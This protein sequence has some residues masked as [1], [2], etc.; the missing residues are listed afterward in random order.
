MPDLIV[1]LDSVAQARD[2]R[3]AQEPDPAAAAV[4]AEL[5]GA[6]GVSIALRAER[7]QS[8]E[9]DAKVLRATVRS[10]LLLRIAASPDSVKLASP[11]RPDAAVLVPERVDPLGHEAPFDLNLSS[12]AVQEAAQGLAAA[13]IDALVLVEPD[14]EQVKLA[15][16]AGV[17]GVSLVGARLG[18]ARQPETEQREWEALERAV[19][20]A[21][22]LGLLAHVAHGLT[23][24][25]AARAARLPGL[26]ALEVGHAVFARGLLVG[27]ERAVRDLRAALG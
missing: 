3:R 6:D 1:G 23:L 27:Y 2:A 19:K 20:L 11:I 18:A 17:R 22:K 26:A 16:R 10:R 14:V 5:G 4:L 9:R 21:A 25:A 15:H 12:A 13:G 24:R 8:Q 7:R